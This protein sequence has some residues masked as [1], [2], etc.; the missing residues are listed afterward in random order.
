MANCGEC[1][2]SRFSFRSRVHRLTDNA[3]L[4]LESF[5]Y[6]ALRLGLTINAVYDLYKF[7]RRS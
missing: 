7:L 4:L 6:L 3:S 5:W 1:E 2:S